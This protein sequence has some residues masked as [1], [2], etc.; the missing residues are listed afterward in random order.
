MVLFGI[1]LLFLRL[2]FYPSKIADFYPTEFQ[3]KSSAQF[4]YSVG[5]ELKF[6]NQLDPGAPTLLRA[7]IRFF[8]VSPDSQKI[9]VSSGS[10]LLVVDRNGPAIRQ[11]AAVYSEFKGYA[12]PPDNKKPI[13]QHYFRNTGFQWSRDSKSLYVIGDEFYNS[14]G[15]QLFS[16]RG[17][18]W[19]Y[20]LETGSL[21]L[22]IKPFRAHKYFLGI[23]S[24]I[25][26]WVP[27]KNGCFQLE[28]FDGNQPTMC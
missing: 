8:L 13:G 22:L 12:P 1:F 3:A 28:Y 18:L 21:Q 2:S 4:F 25:Y 10:D 17:E 20:D 15:G 9:A 6:S 24:G 27:S 23:N 19:R 16:D 11:V 7:P 14:Q 5:D 26:F